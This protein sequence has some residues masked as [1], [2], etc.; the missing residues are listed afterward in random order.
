MSLE[1]H[2]SNNIVLQDPKPFCCDK[3]VINAKN[4]TLAG[5][6]HMALCQNFM[7]TDNHKTAAIAHNSYHIQA[8]PL[9][10]IAQ[11]NINE[12]ESNQC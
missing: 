8:I 7:V 9:H 3:L 6:F 5:S 4:V 10:H 1:Q 11:L 2:L 12:V